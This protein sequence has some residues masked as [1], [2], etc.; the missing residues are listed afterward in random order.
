[1]SGINFVVSVG[2]DQHQVLHVPL[3]QKILKQIER[4][5]VEPLQ[6]VEE[7]GKGMLR[8]CKYGY[9]SSEDQLE[10]ALSVLGGEEPEPATVRR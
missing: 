5:R 10:P 1:M 7:E 2:P 8:P 9:E 6:I 3:D 4:C